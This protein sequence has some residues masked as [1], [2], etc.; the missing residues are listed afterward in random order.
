MASSITFSFLSRSLQHTFPLQ[1]REEN[2]GR[3]LRSKKL[4]CCYSL[5]VPVCRK[6][7]STVDSWQKDLSQC[8]PHRSI[9][10]MLSNSRNNRCKDLKHH[11]CIKYNKTTTERLD[12]DKSF[13]LCRTMVGGQKEG[14]KDPWGN[15]ARQLG[16]TVHLPLLPW[17]KLGAQSESSQTPQ[18]QSWGYAIWD[19]WKASPVLVHIFFLLFYRL[20]LEQFLKLPNYSSTFICKCLCAFNLCFR[21]ITAIKPSFLLHWNANCTTQVKVPETTLVPMPWWHIRHFPAHLFREKTEAT[22]STKRE[23]HFVEG[24]TSL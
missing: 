13:S 17:E 10:N 22:A 12:S 15:L 8:W 9:R 4:F 23:H 3:P 20:L 19:L 2:D 1:K 18:H 5:I 24:N 21:S 6:H 16:S 11:S 14:E 7:Q